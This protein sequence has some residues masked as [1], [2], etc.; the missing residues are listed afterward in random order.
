MKFPTKKC[1]TK[2]NLNFSMWKWIDSMPL[3]NGED[4]KFENCNPK[5]SHRLLFCSRSIVECQILDSLLIR[6]LSSKKNNNSKYSVAMATN[7][8]AWNNKKN[9]FMESRILFYKA[10][11]FDILCDHLIE[12]FVCFHSALQFVSSFFGMIW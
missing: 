5:D 3:N 7:H 10:N 11:D 9:F 2:F 12:W 4:G 8:R 1:C 6:S